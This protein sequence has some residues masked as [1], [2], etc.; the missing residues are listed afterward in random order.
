MSLTKVSYSMIQGAPINAKDFGAV[1]D[2][3]T[4]DT[5][6]MIAFA[7]AP[8]N[9]KYIP[10]GRYKVTQ[11]ISFRPGDTV[12]GA[13]S[14]S[15]IDASAASTWSDSAVVRVAG[16]LTQI[17]DLNTNPN[18]N[19]QILSFVS[20]TGISAGNALIIYNPTNKSWSTWRNEY[21]SGEFVRV[22]SVVG[23]DVYIMNGL[24]DS[25]TASAV[26]VY[27]LD[28]ASTV[29]QN[30]VVLAPSLEVVGVQMSC[31]DRPIMNNV[32]SV[33][34]LGSSLEF[35]RCM[36]I[37]FDGVAFQTQVPTGDEYGLTIANC[38]GGTIRSASLY[39]GRHAL[40]IG[41]YSYVGSVTN[42]A[43]NVYVSKMGNYAPI[44]SQDLHGNTEDLRFFGGTFQNGGTLA[45]KSH[46][47]VGCRFVGK[48]NSGI[49]LY[50]GEIVAGTFEF[51]N[52]SFE[53]TVDPNASNYGIVDLSNLSSNVSSNCIFIFNNCTYYVPDTTVYVIK[54]SITG[55][56]YPPT[57]IVNGANLKA[58]GVTQFIRLSRSS[59]TATINRVAVTDIYNLPT[60]ASYVVNAGSGLTVTRYTLPIQ[61]GT[62]TVAGVTTS[63]NATGVAT[64][65]NPYPVAPTVSA[66]K[67][68]GT[69]I[70]GTAFAP[71]VQSVN[72]TTATLNATTLSGSNYANTNTG[73]IGW[74]AMLMQSEV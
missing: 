48:L 21:K 49:S 72:T 8:V 59:G 30:F 69:T 63:N 19:D 65:N 20:S 10:E 2:G 35:E 64:F 67:P 54:L 47:F 52:C 9:R 39:A 41:G 46:K 40:A 55:T 36:D 68:S 7:N 58:S 17:S 43:I 60:G 53:S 6:A 32:W 74:Q 24:Y 57:I 26:D 13:G 3:V 14:S 44:G 1:G 27:R 29:F 34:A 70:G 11:M 38:H 62:I 4:D 22:N 42:R 56:N 45:G 50:G 23:N 25:Y 37:Q 51:T 33:N 71:D 15:I 18:I 73:V 31:I 61:Y 12:E 16:A 5:A 28:G 66:F